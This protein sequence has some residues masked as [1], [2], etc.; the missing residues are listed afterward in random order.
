MVWYLI[1]PALFYFLFIRH[2]YS[3]LRSVKQVDTKSFAGIKVSVIIPCNNEENN[4]PFLLKDLK[5][6]NYD[7]DLFEVL[8][9]DDNSTDSTFQFA[10]SYKGIRNYRCLRNLYKGKKGAIIQAADI[11][12]GELIMTTDAD[13]RFG[14]GWISAHVSLYNGLHPDLIIGPVALEKGSGFL[15][16][17]Q[18]LEFLS[19]QGITAGTAQNG[20]PVM[21]NGANLSFKK[22]SY[23][24]HSNNL[25]NDIPSGDDV[26]L[27][28]SLKRDPSARILWLNNP[29]GMVTTKQ[30]NTLF[31]YI[32]QRARW[33]SKAGKYRDIYTINLAI[34]TFAVIISLVFLLIEG[35]WMPQFLYIFLI[36]LTIKS[37][38]DFLLIREVTRQSGNE[39]LMKWFIPSQL[40]YPFYVL[41]VAVTALFI[42]K[43]WK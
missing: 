26:F 17:F 8:V 10:S 36:V 9:I 40:V 31:S 43:K 15:G 11:A 28:H 4:L 32:R 2:I 7:P 33:I 21:C 37:I 34:V 5:L 13:C 39:H 23:L 35:L 16:R 30:C 12:S 42:G 1:I 25:R 6:Q 41:A 18:E 3:H 38:P 20:N 19:L 24:R 27:L 22:S 14:P 29:E